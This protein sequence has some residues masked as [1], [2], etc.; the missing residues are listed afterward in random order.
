MLYLR[1]MNKRYE[2]SLKKLREIFPSR[3]LGHLLKKCISH[4][5]CQE[6]SEFGLHVALRMCVCAWESRKDLSILFVCI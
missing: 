5:F 4:A 1:H 2:Q 3:S 6:I